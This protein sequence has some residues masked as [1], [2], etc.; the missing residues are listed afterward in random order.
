MTRVKILL[1][2]I[3]TV[4]LTSCSDDAIY[5]AYVP[6][7][8]SGWQEDSVVTFDVDV[9]DTTSEF[10]VIVMLR[11]NTQYPY[12]NFWLNREITF[13][14]EQIHTDKISYQLAKPTGEWLGKGFGDIKTVEAPYNRQILRFQNKGTYQFRFQQGMREDHL[15]GIEEI[16]LRIVPVND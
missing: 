10:G 16:G 3:I 4:A 13:G 12:Q 11:H 8:D 6:I 7:P 5:D 15:I 9:D 2:L 1:K 14:G